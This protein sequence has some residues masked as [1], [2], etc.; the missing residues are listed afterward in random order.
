MRESI[1]LA[2]FET[3]RRIGVLKLFETRGDVGV[4]AQRAEHLFADLECVQGKSENVSLASHA[5][6]SIVTGFA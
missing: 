1:P 3:A 6:T 4:G 5:V 2:H